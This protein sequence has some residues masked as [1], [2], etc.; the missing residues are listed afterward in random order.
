M[1]RAQ[2]RGLESED[3]VP[4]LAQARVNQCPPSLTRCAT[5]YPHWTPPELSSFTTA[6]WNP[7]LGAPAALTL[8]TK[9]ALCPGVLLRGPFLPSCAVGCITPLYRWED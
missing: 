3:Q 2:S 7:A 9:G 8:G 6:R 4:V 1:V 5:A